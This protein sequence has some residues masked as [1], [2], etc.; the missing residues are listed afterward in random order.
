L[1]QGFQPLTQKHSRVLS[2]ISLR[3]L[4]LCGKSFS[5]A[6]QVPHT[7][8]NDVPSKRGLSMPT[9]DP[10]KSPQKTP[11]PPLPTPPLDEVDESSEES[12]PASDPP[13]FNERGN[14]PKKSSPNPRPPKQT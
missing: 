2:R 12:F 7:S 3:P 13:S 9:T 11:T 5:A 6:P 1:R 4:R 10:K 14:N 8:S